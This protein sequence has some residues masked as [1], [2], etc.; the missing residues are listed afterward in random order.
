[1]QHC[2]QE[3]T[4]TTTTKD[5]KPADKPKRMQGLVVIYDNVMPVFP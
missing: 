4:V 2:G 1:M 3:N 5:N